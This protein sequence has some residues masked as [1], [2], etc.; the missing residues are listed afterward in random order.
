M[1][2]GFYF[3]LIENQDVIMELINDDLVLFLETDELESILYFLYI[4]NVEV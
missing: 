1:K 2:D 3:W 4:H